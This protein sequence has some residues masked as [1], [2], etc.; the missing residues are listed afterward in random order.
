MDLVRQALEAMAWCDAHA[1]QHRVDEPLR[2]P[3]LRPEGDLAFWYDDPAGFGYLESTRIEQPAEVAFRALRSASTVAYRR[4]TVDRLIT[5]RRKLL[6]DSGWAPELTLSALP[7]GRFLLCDDPSNTTNEGACHLSS[8]GFFDWSS[9]TSPWDCWVHYAPAL[10]PIMCEPELWLAH[11][12]HIDGGKRQLLTWVPEA[13]V[14]QA[15]A[16]IY[17]SS[18]EMFCWATE[19]DADDP[20][21]TALR[22]A[23]LLM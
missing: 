8:G 20:F 10:D 9:D 11:A 16:G 22:T 1:E 17:V 12:P 21:V 3:A 14:D 15:A 6:H 23:G 2:S 7:R 5:Q 4:R 13:W 19:A 18:T